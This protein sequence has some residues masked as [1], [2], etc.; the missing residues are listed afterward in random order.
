MLERIM[1]LCKVNK[2]NGTKLGEIL[3]L[4]KSPITDWKNQKAKPTLEQIEKMCEIF[5]VSA[6]YIIFGKEN[7]ELTPAEQELLEAY[8]KAALEDK[9]A[10]RKMLDLPKLPPESTSDRLGKSSISENGKEAI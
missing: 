5:A 4:K 1:E 7:T 8:R 2:I 3:G 10:A 9:N 6:D